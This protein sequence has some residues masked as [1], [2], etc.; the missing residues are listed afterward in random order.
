M[1]KYVL[2][3][4]NYIFGEHEPNAHTVIEVKNNDPERTIKEYFENFY[5]EENLNEA[6]NGTYLYF[7]GKFGLKINGIIF[8]NTD[9]Y[10]TLKKLGLAY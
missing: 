2:V 3:R 8:L 6:D 5:G 1:K 9:E 10:N 4:F 7:G